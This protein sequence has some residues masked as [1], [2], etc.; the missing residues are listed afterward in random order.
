MLS[1]CLGTKHLK[2]NEKLLYHQSIQAP[3]NINEEDLRNLY[4]KRP[5]RRL[6]GLPIATLVSV[7]YM[8][9]KR[10]HQDK[11]IRKKEAFEKKYDQKIARATSQ[12]KINK[13]QFK[14]QKKVDKMNSY[15]ENGNLLMQWG[16]P[17]SLFDSSQV[18]LTTER[19]SSYLFSK[20]YFN[21]SVSSRLNVQEKRVRV[22]YQVNPGRP[23]ILDS[24]VYDISDT[25]ILNIMNKNMSETLLIRRANYDQENFTKERERIDFLLK[26][27][28]YYD[29]SRQ[30]IDFEVDTTF[31]RPERKVAVIVTIREPEKRG[32]HK[33]FLI[34]KITFTTRVD[35]LPA[36]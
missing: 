13:F 18:A 17:L 27:N 12:K 19:F 33:R 3:K 6:M 30:Y 26:D 22:N 21:N 24:I 25:A 7:Y 16:E 29:F 32:Y 8:G 1:G 4:T 36:E 31:R 9:E 15:I 20:G 5:N 11:Y 14:R 2:E 23:Y 10:Y 35:V 34:D 28:G